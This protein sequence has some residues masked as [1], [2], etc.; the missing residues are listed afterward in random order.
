MKLPRTRTIT[1]SIYECATS[2]AAA[3]PNWGK[4]KRGDMEVTGIGT[5]SVIYH[6]N[7][8]VRTANM[9][10]LVTGPS[11]LTNRHITVHNNGPSSMKKLFSVRTDLIL[12]LKLCDLFEAEAARELLKPLKEEGNFY[13][14]ISFRNRSCLR[15]S[16]CCSE[17][18]LTALRSQLKEEVDLS[19]IHH[20]GKRRGRRTS[21]H[22]YILKGT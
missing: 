6:V 12:E 18:G 8:H 20:H 14:K 1:S 11:N 19:S 9:L 3:I 5:A 10:R 21:G 13:S 7:T 17:P 22:E 4:R 15:S 2:S 16:L